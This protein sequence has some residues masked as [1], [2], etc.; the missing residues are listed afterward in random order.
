VR[1]ESLFDDLEGQARAQE[2]AALDSEVADLARAERAGV[3][4]VDR[5][6]AHRGSSLALR[7]LDGAA[8]HVVVDDVGA[9]CLLVRDLP[10]RSAGNNLATPSGALVPL[11]AV[12]SVEGLGHGADPGG[13][14]SERRLGLAAA[15][16]RVARDRAPVRVELRDRTSL[17]GTVDRVG[18]DHL[19]LAAHPQDV[20]R[21]PRNVTHV[22]ALP[23]AA[24]VR[25]VLF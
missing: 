21:R 14:T 11:H 9:D 5:L 6:R 25:I 16:R 24:V 13:T 1:W 12:V 15:L 8:L 2:Q 7:L 22:P 20:A 17:T 18:A 19:D 10:V 3:P 4:L 23:F